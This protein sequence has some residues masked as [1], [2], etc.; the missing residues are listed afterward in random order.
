MTSSN[1]IFTCS[2]PLPSP[3]LLSPPLQSSPSSPP[4]PALPIPSHQ[5][6][7]LREGKGRRIL[8]RCVLEGGRTDTH[9]RN[10]G[11]NSRLLCSRLLNSYALLLSLPSSPLSS[12]SHSSPPVFPFFASSPL[13]SRPLTPTPSLPSPSRLGKGRGG[14]FCSGEV[15]QGDG[16]IHTRVARA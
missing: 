1:T 6:H 9:A 5:P 11:L 12:P 15:W 14:E 3:P 8:Q 13:S 7:S 10:A 16:Q 2:T 4:L